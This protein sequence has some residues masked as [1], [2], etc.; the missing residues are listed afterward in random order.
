MNDSAQ[1]PVDR[2]LLDEFYADFKESQQDCDDLLLELESRPDDQDLINRIFRSIHTIKGNLLYVGLQDLS[3]LFQHIEGILDKLRQKSIRY[4]S[5]LSDMILLA[6]DF[7]RS[8]IDRFLDNR[9]IV[10]DH[11]LKI[12]NAVARIGEDS[13]ENIQINAISAISLLDPD[14]HLSKDDRNSLDDLTMQF[15]ISRSVDLDFFVS[16]IEPLETRSAYWQGRTFR[17]LSLGLAMNKQ[18]GTP[19]DPAQLAAAVIMHDLGMSFL[20][21][22]LL[23]KKNKLNGTEKRTMQS[24]LRTGYDLLHRMAEWQEAA[25]IVQQHHEHTDGRGY[26]K[27]LTELEICDGAKILAIADT[28]EARTHERAHTTFAKRPFIRA[29][30]EL[31]KF[32]GSQFNQHWIDIFNEVVQQGSCSSHLI[33]TRQRES[34]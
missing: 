18:A 16:L 9:P 25:E 17:I 32:S 3:P 7:A 8:Q 23:H 15:Q 22:Q 30:L 14:T 12:C 29:V 33:R 1:Q 21:L 26:P 27:K 19:V 20:P 31:N 28:F 24:H 6:L 34:A 5:A 4:D 13:A 2:A 10:T 11:F